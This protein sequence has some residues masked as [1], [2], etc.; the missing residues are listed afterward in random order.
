MHTYCERHAYEI[1]PVRGMPMA[2]VRG[3]P[4]GWSME[5]ARLYLTGMQLL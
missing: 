5:D 4:M 3:T 1:A 2:P